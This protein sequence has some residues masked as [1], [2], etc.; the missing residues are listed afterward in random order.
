MKAKWQR[1]VILGA[2]MISPLAHGCPACD[3]SKKTVGSAAAEVRTLTP[4][5]LHEMRGTRRVYV[6]DANPRDIFNQYHVPEAVHVEYDQITAS[7]LPKDQSALIVFY[8]MNERCGAS[9]VA[10]K[11]ATE[12][13]WRNVYL[14]PAGIQGWLAMGLKVEAT[15][16]NRL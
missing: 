2:V 8:C 5:Q 14:M 15:T 9:P 6:F 7:Q 3:D 13:G 11:R 10:A 12:L 1:I 16:K 4:A